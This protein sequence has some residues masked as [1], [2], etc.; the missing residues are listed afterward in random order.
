MAKDV[1]TGKSPMFG[2]SRKHKRGSSG[3][4]GVW[5]F[6]AQATPKKW[7]IN[8]R[9]VKLVEK[10][11]GKVDTYTVSMKTYKRLRNF[12]SF[13]GFELASEYQN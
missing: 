9:K 4:G 5:R 7:K 2:K 3:G 13:Q 11:T 1:L 12:G 6:K 8:S 10:A